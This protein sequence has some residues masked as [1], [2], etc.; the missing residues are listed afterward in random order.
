MRSLKTD[1]FSNVGVAKV[2]RGSTLL[3]EGTGYA[4]V[5]AVEADS[6]RGFAALNEF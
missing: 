6:G 2:V 3:R 5:P 4:A 1:R